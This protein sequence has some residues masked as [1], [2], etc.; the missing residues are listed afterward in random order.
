MS[1]AQELRDLPPQYEP[2][3][4]EHAIYERW[5]AADIFSAD[6][7]RSRRNGGDRDPFVIVMPPPNVTSV[8]HMGHGLNNTVQ[9]VIIR[10]RRMVGDEALWVPGT[11][12]AGIATQ[13]IIEKQLAAE[14]KTKADLGREAFVARTIAFVEETG[15]E[16]LRQLRAIGASAD[17]NRTAYTLSPE[18]SRAVR[19]A[20]VQLYERGLIYRGHRVI[21]WCPRCMTSLSD[22]EAE[23]DEEMGRLYQI[24]YPVVGAKSNASLI[25]AT[26]RPETM[27]GDVA[28][29]VHPDDDRYRQLIGKSVRLPI[30]NVEIHVIADEYVD[31][32]FGTGVVKITPSHDA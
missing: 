5:I 14:G 25:V 12:H 1:T 18:L 10:W 26:T 31:P 16:I 21:H 7:K 6:E 2:G 29:A 11:D 22:E 20:F 17:W 4:I 19:E 13:N 32:A 8:L 30:A 28:V 24:A 9:D 27:L 23:H 3:Q 15:G